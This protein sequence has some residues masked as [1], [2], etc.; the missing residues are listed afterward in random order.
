M[1]SCFIIIKIYYQY[2]QT[3]ME[4]ITKVAETLNRIIDDDTTP[5]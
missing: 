5:S 1:L 4:K 3:K 2:Y